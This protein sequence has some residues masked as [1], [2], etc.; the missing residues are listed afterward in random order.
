MR[1]RVPEPGLESASRAECLRFDC[2]DL[3]IGAFGL[4]LR[5]G[6]QLNR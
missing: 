4:G 5:S 6:C 1:F 3:F 2:L